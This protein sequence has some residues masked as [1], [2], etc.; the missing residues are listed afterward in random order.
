MSSTF[1]RQLV[2]L[3]LVVILVGAC[4]DDDGG[5]GTTTT[6]AAGTST[7][8]AGSTTA[9]ATSLTL[10]VEGLAGF[11]GR[12]VVGSLFSAEGGS[13]GVQGTVCLQ[14]DADPWTGSGVFSTADPSNPCGKDSPFGEVIRQEG[15]YSL[16]VGVYTPGETTP[17]VCLN[18]TATISGPSEVVV[19]AADMVPNC[20]G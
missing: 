7:N 9:G 19:A 2:V 1:V 6:A 5:E 13:G 14:V 11:E 18:T 15:D 12:T 3:G 17:A 20:T 8:A 4:G 16:I 10:I